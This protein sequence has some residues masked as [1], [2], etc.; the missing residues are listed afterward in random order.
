M[1]TIRKGLKDE[2]NTQECKSI[3]TK[4]VI[5]TKVFKKKKVFSWAIN[6]TIALIA[7]WSRVYELK[8]KT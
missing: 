2:M 6:G 1:D 5:T 3:Q 8:G 7:L 4:L